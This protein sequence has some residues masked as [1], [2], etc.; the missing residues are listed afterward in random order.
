MDSS[1]PVQAQSP[2]FYTEL[3]QLNDL[4]RKASGDKE[5]ALKEVAQ[6]F[7][8]IFLSMM[9]KSM[10]DA[11]ASF[12]ED[13]PFNGNNTRF[14]QDMYDQQMTLDLSQNS[15]LGLAEIM[16]R[17]LSQVGDLRNQKDDDDK[18]PA[19]IKTDTERMLNTAVD[20]TARLAASAVLGKAH[21]HASGGGTVSSETAKAIKDAEPTISSQASKTSDLAE[22]LPQ[23]FNSPDEFVS[24]LLPL[25]ENVAK[26]LGVDP[27]VLLA[28]AALETGWGRFVIEGS[29]N[30]FNI[31][32]DRRWDGDRVSVS[33]LEYRQGQAQREMASFR[34]YANYEES[35][36][37]YVDFLKTNPRYQ[38]ALQNT[39]NPSAYLRELQAAGYATDPAYAKKIE[40]IYS[41]SV[42]ARANIDTQEG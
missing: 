16:V 32:A 29:H 8:Q 36:R 11:N 7:E 38:Q 19:Q 33:T 22:N 28:Q 9:L 10:R 17:Q 4:R 39:S 25:A 40:Q 26:D 42:M 41:G 31:K 15:R 23:R 14:Y 12:A 6:Q 30:L 2:Q 18:S 5:A 21:T 13:N 37:D 3:N 35:F 24:A 1:K 20:A 34:S 27:K